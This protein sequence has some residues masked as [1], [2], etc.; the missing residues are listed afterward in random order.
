MSH[1]VLPLSRILIHKTNRSYSRSKQL[2]R[3]SLDPEHHHRPSIMS[4]PEKLH[5]IY[6]QQMTKR[7]DYGYPLYN[8]TSRTIIKPG[9]CG[10]IDQ[11][12]QWNPVADLTTPDEL[13][14]KGLT[15]PQQPLESAPDDCDI[16]W[17]P[18]CSEAVKGRRL[19]VEAGAS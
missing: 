7:H 18:K 3:A 12:G 16:S 10:Y 15:P 19:G 4:P 8:P 2:N 9:V 5:E 11:H 1:T 13:I 14:K 17:G 6:A